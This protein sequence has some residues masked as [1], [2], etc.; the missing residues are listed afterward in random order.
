MMIF[1][2]RGNTITRKDQ[3]SILTTNNVNSVECKFSFDATYDDLDKFAVFYRDD[4]L[5]RFV[6]IVDGTCQ[7]PWDLLLTPGVLHVGAY[8]IKNT[9]DTVKKRVT[10]N[11]VLLLISQDLSSTTAVNAAPAPDIWE[12]YRADILSM[13]NAAVKAASDAADSCDQAK[14]AAQTVGILTESVTQDKNTVS[15]AC[16]SALNASNLAAEAKKAAQ[17]SA[18]AA[19]EAADAAERNTASVLDAAQ[20][21]A[22]AASSAAQAAQSA[23]SDAESAANVLSQIKDKTI[24]RY[25]AR[26]AIGQAASGLERIWD[27]VGLSANVGIDSGSAVNDFDALYPWSEMRVCNI[28]VEDGSV[29]VRAYQ[30]E[31][32]FSSDGSNGNV[33]IEVPLFYQAPRFPGDGYEY[34]G[35]S[36][37]PIGG[38]TV[39]PDFIGKNGQLLPKVYYAKYNSG[40]TNID[41]VDTIVSC[42]GLPADVMRSRASTRTLAQEVGAHLI[43]LPFHDILSTLFTVEFAT[44]NSQRIM[45]GASTLPYSSSHRPAIAEEQANRVILPNSLAAEYVTDVLIDIATSLGGRQVAKNRQILSITDYDADHKAITF[46][47]EPV[48]IT[49]DQYVYAVGWLSGTTDLVAASSGSPVSNSSGKYPCQYRGI[50]NPWGNVYQWLDGLNI[51]DHQAWVC[52]SPED[53]ADYMYAA[54]YRKLNYLNGST[55]GFVKEFGRDQR[56]SWAKLPVEIGATDSNYYADYYYQTAGERATAFGGSCSFGGYA[57]LWYLD[58]SNSPLIQLVSFGSRLMWKPE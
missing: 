43:G 22:E 25:G 47:G 24:T 45:M 56:Y 23:S 15:Q 50:E 44:L 49:T 19:I 6:P 5:N 27:A 32:G 2:V 46:S 55:N 36:A 30:G 18:S 35:V 37:Y 21:A 38:W 28:G 34:W 39:N 52:T 57:G 31:S 7:I 48:D 42:A 40:L 9:Q 26:R 17:D 54:P 3:N 11:Y 12:M 13:Q 33:A 16:N 53:Y 58:S 10:T 29:Y 1:E 41:G 51:K 20:S 4:T 14:A 8:G